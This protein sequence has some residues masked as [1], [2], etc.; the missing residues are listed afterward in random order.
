M[1]ELEGF[2]PEEGKIFIQYLR[3]LRKLHSM[4][5]AEKLDP[6][7]RQILSEYEGTFEELYYQEGL[8]MPLKVHVIVHHFSEYLELKGETMKFTN[9]EFVETVHQTLHRHE[10]VHGYPTVRKMIVNGQD[11]LLHLK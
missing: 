7:Y 9:G 4:S 10:N 3:N 2:L 8:N 1:F 5:V 6:N 11:F